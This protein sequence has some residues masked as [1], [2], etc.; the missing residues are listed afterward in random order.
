V[1]PHRPRKTQ[2]MMKPLLAKT[3]H[4]PPAEHPGEAPTN[5]RRLSATPGLRFRRSPG[6]LCRP[7]QTP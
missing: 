1:V 4:R 2:P 5:G 6:V 3:T 7:F